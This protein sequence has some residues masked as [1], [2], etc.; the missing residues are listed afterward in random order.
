MPRK[1]KKKGGKAATS[2]REEESAET[3]KVR[4]T[5]AVYCVSLTFN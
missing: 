5:Y 1:G 2:Q 3:Y 4:A